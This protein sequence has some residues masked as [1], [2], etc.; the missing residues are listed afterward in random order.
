MAIIK[1][2]FAVILAGVFLFTN[3][4]G[5]AKEDKLFSAGTENKSF[6]SGPASNSKLAPKILLSDAEKQAEFQAALICEIIEKRALSNYGKPVYLDD[7]FFWKNSSEKEFEGCRFERLGDEIRI[8]LPTANIAV[9]YF[10]PGLSDKVPIFSDKSREIKSVSINGRLTRQIIHIIKPL[11]NLSQTS[12]DIDKDLIDISRQYGLNPGVVAQAVNKYIDP[13]Q[14]DFFQALDD[15][16]GEIDNPSY[17]GLDEAEVLELLE[18]CKVHFIYMF[19][20]EP[21][22]YSIFANTAIPRIRQ[23]VGTNSKHVIEYVKEVFGFIGS[24]AI[25][26]DLIQG[27]K[28]LE[29]DVKQK[30]LTDAEIEKAISLRERLKFDFMPII[31][32]VVSSIIRRNEKTLG[33]NYNVLGIVIYGSVARGDVSTES[34]IDYG[35]ITRTGDNEDVYNFDNELSR[36]L[37]RQGVPFAIDTFHMYVGTIEEIEKTI[38]AGDL[39]DAIVI[40]GNRLKH[41]LASRPLLAGGSETASNFGTKGTY[42]N[43]WFD[44]KV[45][46]YIRENIDNAIEIIIQNGIIINPNEV[47]SPLV[48]LVKPYLEKTGMSQF[49]GSNRYHLFLFDTKTKGTEFGRDPF[50]LVDKTEKGLH[51][52]VYAH[53]GTGGN[54]RQR[55]SIYMPFCLFQALAANEPVL[56]LN[57][58]LPEEVEHAENRVNSRAAGKEPTPEIFEDMPNRQERITRLETFI[59]EHQDVA[60]YDTTLFRPGQVTRREMLKAISSAILF[61]SFVGNIDQLQTAARSL[62]SD[63]SSMPNAEPVI[64]DFLTY[65]SSTT[66][67]MVSLLGI[68]AYQKVLTNVED[69]GNLSD[70]DFRKTAA[71]VLDIVQGKSWWAGGNIRQQQRWLQESS[72]K[73][74][75]GASATTTDEIRDHLRTLVQYELRIWRP[76]TSP[77]LPMYE[78]YPDNESFP[79]IGRPVE[80]ID[81]ALDE[82]TIA[83][84][85]DEYIPQEVKNSD[86]PNARADYIKKRIRVLQN[87][88]KLLSSREIQ[89]AQMRSI[90]SHGFETQASLIDFVLQTFTNLIDQTRKFV[91][92]AVTDHAK[93]GSR[94]A[95]RRERTLLDDLRSSFES[96]KQG[97]IAQEY[98]PDKIAVEKKIDK[99]KLEYS[100]L[101]NQNKN[102]VST[103]LVEG[104]NKILFRISQE[105]IKAD[106]DGNIKGL[107]EVLQKTPNG[108]VEIFSEKGGAVEEE[109]AKL[110]TKDLSKE[111]ERTKE[112]TITLFTVL[113][114]EISPDEVDAQKE[115]N[116]RLRTRIGSVTPEQTQ[117]VPTGLQDDPAGIVRNVFIG[118]RCIYIA[119]QKKELGQVDEE[120]AKET[121]EQ[122]KNLCTAQGVT[123]FNL[124]SEDIINIATGKLNELIHALSRLIRLLP[125][126]PIDMET[127]RRI[128]EN[129]KIVIMAA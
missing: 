71:A 67:D 39:K 53:A 83:I 43:P 101:A 85:Q 120:F 8:Y 33:N 74:R 119:R 59:S 12:V 94:V 14:E 121:A 50:S 37:R 100:S 10:D 89:P 21:E 76:D 30:I 26:G 5:W 103:L 82:E 48:G 111:F 99:V 116:R 56:N 126:K 63:I 84:H 2:T 1:K 62:S 61:P 16:M 93:V 95:E 117:I 107:I 25:S 3:T 91:K 108:H 115:L 114:D 113:K 44:R 90:L 129:A 122:L 54:N 20:P 58:I 87:V 72:R 28:K 36:E 51:D 22:L 64:S 40:G 46:Q 65:M 34:D 105:R 75:E 17:R 78:Q 18:L 96:P 70:E 23:I 9:R 45:S 112:N 92:T 104:S 7:I 68:P 41:I 13:R 60:S 6:S 55:R 66:P 42:V 38:S 127:L 29:E 102:L 128:Y 15:K 77:V 125:I 118:L 110:V 19:D 109:Y 69:Y 73:L 32:K 98:K 81:L 97:E 49:R 79:D 88:D 31:R 80:I 123:N 47:P 106:E 27:Y 124:T 52:K 4:F 86:N 57:L 35:I 24:Y 11:P